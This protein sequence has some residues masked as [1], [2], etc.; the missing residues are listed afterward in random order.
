MRNIVSGM[1]TTR[2]GKWSLRSFVASVLFF[3]AAIVVLNTVGQGLVVTLL[4][5]AAAGGALACSVL[6][7]VAI[8]RHGERTLN[9]YGGLALSALFLILLLH[10]L[11]ISD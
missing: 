8:F 10:S 4:G 11:F 2:L 7:V 9:V 5:I 3:V 6:A 1:P